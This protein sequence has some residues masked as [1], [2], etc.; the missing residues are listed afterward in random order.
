MKALITPQRVFAHF[1]RP[2]E[3]WLILNLLQHLVNW[4]SEHGVHC[5]GGHTLGLPNKVPLSPAT[6]IMI[7]PE[8]PPLLRDNLTFP[9]I[10]LLVLLHPFILVNL[11]HEQAYI[12]NRL[13]SQRLP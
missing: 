5:S 11:I 8:I 1:V 2:F 7:R 3:V 12:G 10:L 4:L 13:Y 9:I 6:A